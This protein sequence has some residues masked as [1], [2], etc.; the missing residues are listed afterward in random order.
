[1]SKFTLT[2]LWVTDR[3]LSPVSVEEMEQKANRIQTCVIIWHS[4]CWCVASYMIQRG[5]LWQGRQRGQSHGD[6]EEAAGCR[7]ARW[8][9]VSLPRS[10]WWGHV[11]HHLACWCFCCREE[12]LFYQPPLSPLPLWSDGDPKNY[13]AYYSRATVFLA[14]GKS[15]SALPDL[16]KVIE[17]KPDFTSVSVKSDISLHAGRPVSNTGHYLKTNK[18]NRV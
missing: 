1:M 10:C 5:D 6:G 11:K 8:C 13:M 14:M 4:R 15:K 12:A 18:Q 2:Y 7:A 9:S 3:L 17:L 16:G